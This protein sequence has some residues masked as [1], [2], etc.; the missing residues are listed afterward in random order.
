VTD[1]LR[2][3][4]AREQAARAADVPAAPL[5]SQSDLGIDAATT[6]ADQRDE[7]ARTRMARMRG[8]ENAAA[9]AAMTAASRKEILPDIEEINSTL[10][11]SAERGETHPPMP[12]DVVASDKRGFRFGFF[13]G[14]LIILALVALYLFADTISARVPATE[15]ALNSYVSSVDQARLWLD[16]QITGLL[17]RI[18]PAA[19][20]GGS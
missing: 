18:D 17:D 19:Q 16:M 2:E 4:A 14:L 3:E 5:E 11:S 7:E 10:R 1:I 20:D 6:V 13:G 12:E 15:G 9:V 8:E